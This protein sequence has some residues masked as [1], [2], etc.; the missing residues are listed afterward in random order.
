MNG[1]FTSNWYARLCRSG[2]LTIRFADGNTRWQYGSFPHL[3]TWAARYRVHVE[4]SPN[5]GARV[6][7]APLDVASVT[8][9]TVGMTGGE[10]VIAT[11]LGKLRTP[12]VTWE[13]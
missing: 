13:E 2:E 8:W 5:G 11:N 4:F 12:T 6:T 1:L 9:R 3:V 10:T 7:R